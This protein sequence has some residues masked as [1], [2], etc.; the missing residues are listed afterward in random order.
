MI[1]GMLI[2][3]C[4]TSVGISLIASFRS[5]SLFLK[6][7]LTARYL[8]SLSDF[9]T[10]RYIV[11]FPVPAIPFNRKRHFP[12]SDEVHS[13]I[14]RRSPVLVPRRHSSLC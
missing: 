14:C 13:L 9:A 1:S 11:D 8:V 2:V 10:V 7:K 3:N 6:K 4:L 12:F 5:P